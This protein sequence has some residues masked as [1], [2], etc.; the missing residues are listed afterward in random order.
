MCIVY[1]KKYNSAPEKNAYIK[2]SI[3]A[4]GQRSATPWQRVKAYIRRYLSVANALR[5]YATAARTLRVQKLIVLLLAFPA[6]PLNKTYMH[7]VQ[8]MRTYCALCIRFGN[9][10][11]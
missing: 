8:T 5:A 7:Y 4:V 11:E 6:D 1:K 3:A 2:N 9:T 10:L